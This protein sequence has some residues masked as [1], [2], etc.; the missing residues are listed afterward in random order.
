[1]LRA[2]NS[3]VDETR[4]I[5]SVGADLA[6]AANDET[7]RYQ[8]VSLAEVVSRAA[9]SVRPQLEPGREL[10]LDLESE[11]P[12]VRGEPFQ[13]EQV[14]YQLIQNATRAG[15]DGEPVRVEL[16]KTP[17]GVEL[18]IEDKGNGIPEEVLDDVFDPFALETAARSDRGLGLAI[19]YRIVVEHGG[20][21]RVASQIGD[22]TRV[23]VVLPADLAAGGC[24]APERA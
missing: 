23:T 10:A 20:E 18:E 14:A 8:P 13:L 12:I 16:R 21:L 3:C 7:S 19:C 11:L 6:R 2:V 24:T 5:Q 22:G 4:R 1:M 17:D 9:D 15:G